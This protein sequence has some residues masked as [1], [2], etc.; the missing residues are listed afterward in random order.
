MLYTI[1][2]LLFGLNSYDNYCHGI[3][4]YDYRYLANK[5]VVLVTHQLQ[6]IKSVDQV[7]ILDKGKIIA[8]GCFEDL[9]VNINYIPT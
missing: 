7:V 9:D 2:M 3:F 6:F 8:D 4:F 1:G 5:T